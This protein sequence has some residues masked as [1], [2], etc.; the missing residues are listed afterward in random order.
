MTA[1]LVDPDVDL[2]ALPYFPLLR[3]RLFRSEFHLRATDA[4]WRAGLTLWVR[5]FDQQPAG[6]LPDDD[7]QLQRLAGLA[8]QHGKWRRV[9]TMA[10]HGWT[11][12]DDGRL[13]HAT[14]AEVVNIAISR[15]NGA[16]TN[17]TRVRTGREPPLK[18]TTDFDDRKENLK[19]SS[20]D[21]KT[22]NKPSAPARANGH[23]HANGAVG[24]DDFL[25]QNWNPLG[26]SA[27]LAAQAPPK[28]PS[29][30]LRNKRKELLRMKLLRFVD[31]TMKNTDRHK[32]IAGLCG[33]D[34]EHSEQWWL[35]ILDI[36]MRAERWDDVA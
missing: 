26:R 16:K 3:R 10:L 25:D 20:L 15:R 11:L 13:Y 31:A 29:P 1:P 8:R 27:P 28:P 30:A 24:Q 14:V 7:A 32:A 17:Q 33:T 9:R 21:I 22:T 2:T 35:D 12:C 19:D 6:S 18:S 4:E 36:R 23:A 5:S 34:P